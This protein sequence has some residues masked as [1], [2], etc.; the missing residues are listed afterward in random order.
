MNI[1]YEKYIPVPKGGYCDICHWAVSECHCD[2]AKPNT[3]QEDE[4]GRRYS[5]RDTE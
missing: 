3:N 2:E 5:R 1:A 4:H